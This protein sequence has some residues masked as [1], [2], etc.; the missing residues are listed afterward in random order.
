MQRMSRQT[1]RYVLGSIALVS[2]LGLL[3]NGLP[4]AASMSTVPTITWSNHVQTSPSGIDWAS[5]AYGNGHFVAVGSTSTAGVV[6]TSSDGQNWTTTSQGTVRWAVVTYGNGRFVAIGAGISSGTSEAMTLAD[7]SNTWVTGQLSSTSTGWSSLIWAGSQFVAADYSADIYTSPD[8]TTWTFAAT[9][10]GANLGS[11][12]AQGS[13]I[14]GFGSIAASP[15]EWTSTNGG[16]VWSP[17]ATAP[18]YGYGAAAGNG[19]AVIVANPPSGSDT[20]SPVVATSSDGTTWTPQTGGEGIDWNQVSYGDGLFVAEADHYGAYSSPVV[21]VSTDGVSWT[22][23][24][25]AND[26]T[27]GRWSAIAPGIIVTVGDAGQIET[28][29]YSGQDTPTTAPTTTTLQPTV[30]TAGSL[31]S[32][33]L[34]FW[35]AF[36]VG[37]AAIAMGSATL[38]ISRRPRRRC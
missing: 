22:L 12:L 2:G 5:V 7:G 11:L 9:I 21:M 20:T 1:L 30:T 26:L 32:T 27:N 15:A 18:N 17:P 3:A 33:G 25:G 34:N 13:T 36:W 28:G 38:L 29:T 14:Y 10:P 4:A 23:E 8:G 6:A 24:P 31:A 16:S 19:T 35:A 37:L